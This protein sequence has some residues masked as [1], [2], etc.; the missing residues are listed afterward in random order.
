MVKNKILKYWSTLRVRLYPWL[1]PV[2]GYH[3]LFSGILAALTINT[4]ERTKH[5]T[6]TSIKEFLLSLWS[7]NNEINFLVFTCTI[8]EG[9]KVTKPKINNTSRPPRNICQCSV[10]CY[11]LIPTLR[12]FSLIGIKFYD[13]LFFFRYHN[14]SLGNKIN[15]ILR[16]A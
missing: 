3:L 1:C 11:N 15:I 6:L 13:Q 10:N 8:W 5:F 4:W 2:I 14:L 16:N 12:V 7:Q 9:M